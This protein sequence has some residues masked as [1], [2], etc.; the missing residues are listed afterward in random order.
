MQAIFISIVF[1]TYLQ[2]LE[3]KAHSKFL[4]YILSG[5]RKKNTN[6][7]IGFWQTN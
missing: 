7:L 6:D 4:F 2:F 1:I 5:P 3:F